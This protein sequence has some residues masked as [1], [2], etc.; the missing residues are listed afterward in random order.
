MPCVVTSLVIMLQGNLFLTEVGSSF[1]ILLGSE[2]LVLHS[3]SLP[4][5]PSA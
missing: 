2:F 1:V 5:F 3:V 4:I